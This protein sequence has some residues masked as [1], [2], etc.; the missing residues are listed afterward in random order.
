MLRITVMVCM[1][2]GGVALSIPI[3]VY[4]KVGPEY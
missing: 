2:A 3:G 4:Q 1:H